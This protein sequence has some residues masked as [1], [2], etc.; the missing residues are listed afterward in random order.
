MYWLS[1]PGLENWRN[2]RRGPHNGT[3]SKRE[4]VLAN[5]RVTKKE[6]QNWQK[7]GGREASATIDQG[8]QLFVT[9]WVTPED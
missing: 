9:P 8:G 7:D 1:N 5:V 4:P 6:S 2:T 3:R